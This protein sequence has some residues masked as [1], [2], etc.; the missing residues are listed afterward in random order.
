MGS[1][2]R[3]FKYAW[4]TKGFGPT[5]STFATEGHELHRTRRG[6]LAPFFSKASVHQL[7]PSVQSVVSQ[8]ILRLEAVKGSRI[9]IGL[10]DVFAALTSDI[11]GQYA[12]AF[13]YGFIESPEFAPQ[14]HKAMM[15]L[16]ESHNANCFRP[17]ASRVSTTV[18][19]QN[20]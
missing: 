16:S 3:T 10:I 8:L 5:I 6:A 4:A 17:S 9:V 2:R 7:E 11:I 14:W 1:S 15:D 18:L 13:P 20:D 19:T 12:F